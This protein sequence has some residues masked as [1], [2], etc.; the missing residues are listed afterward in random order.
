[1]KSLIILLLTAVCMSGCDSRPAPDPAAM[2]DFKLLQIDTIS[3]AKI[4][5]GT[6]T[7]MF[8]F[9][10]ECPHCQALTDSIVKRIDELKDVRILMLSTA[11]FDDIHSFSERNH[12]EKYSNIVVS[13][14]VNNF[15]PTFF[16]TPGYPCLAIYDQQKKFK[17]FILGEVSVDTLKAII[18]PPVKA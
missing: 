8:Y 18:H 16:K 2:P 17:L 12:L 15:F 4:P 6:P 14:D 13:Q 1:M 9:G 5:T 3:T 11:K 7:I 10:P